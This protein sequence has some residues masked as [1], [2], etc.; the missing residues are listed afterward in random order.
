MNQTRMQRWCIKHQE[1]G[2]RLLLHDPQRRSTIQDIVERKLLLVELNHDWPWWPVRRKIKRVVR[3]W[4]SIIP[5]RVL[6]SLWE[7][8]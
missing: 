1:I 4:L 6:K 3:I 2:N 8:E 7:V 5:T